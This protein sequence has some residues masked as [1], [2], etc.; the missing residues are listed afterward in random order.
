V[1]YSGCMPDVLFITD[2]KARRMA[3]PGHGEATDTLVRAAGG[4]DVN[5]VQHEYYRGHYGFSSAKVQ[6]VLQAMESVVLSPAHC[7]IMMQWF[8]RNPQYSPCYLFSIV[9]IIHCNQ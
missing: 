7:I 5:L 4:D 6:H 1:H 3:W 2:G 9:I 8:W